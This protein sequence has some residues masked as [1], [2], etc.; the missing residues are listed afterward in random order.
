MME[1]WERLFEILM[2]RQISDVNHVLIV[3]VEEMIKLLAMG[4]LAP[5]GRQFQHA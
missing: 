5:E 4:H 3:E 1:P 2:S